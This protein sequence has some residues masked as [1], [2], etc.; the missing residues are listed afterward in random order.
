M[1]WPWWAETP[2]LI[3]YMG[4]LCCWRKFLLLNLAMLAPLWVGKRCQV[5]KHKVHQLIQQVKPSKEQWVDP[6]EQKHHV[7]LPIW[8][9]SAAGE[10]F[11]CSIWI[12]YEP[13]SM[14]LHIF[15]RPSGIPLHHEVHTAEAH[16]RLTLI[17]SELIPGSQWVLWGHSHPHIRFMDLPGSSGGERWL[18]T[19]K[20]GCWRALRSCQGRIFV[21]KNSRNDLQQH[22][23]LLN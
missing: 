15:V 11:F 21:L 22:T 9:S 17:Y 12:C 5:T 1:S 14:L 16:L 8:A 2:C 6:G 3:T 23:Q 7:S 13:C 4:Q 19:I 10:S 18:Q 20:L